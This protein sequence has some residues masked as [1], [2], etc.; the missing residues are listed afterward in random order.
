MEEREMFKT[1]IVAAALAATTAATASPAHTRRQPAPLS[2]SDA[3]ERALR[4]RFPHP[5]TLPLTA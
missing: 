2:P 1:L 5:T 3:L 4:H